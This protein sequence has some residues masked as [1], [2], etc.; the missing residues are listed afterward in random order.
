[1][2]NVNE[3]TEEVKK[4]VVARIK[5]AISGAK[6]FARPIDGQV[7]NIIGVLDVTIPGR[8][9]PYK[10]L[11]AKTDQGDVVTF[12]PSWLYSDLTDTKGNR[13]VST[14]NGNPIHDVDEDFPTNLKCNKVESFTALATVYEDGVAVRTIEKMRYVYHWVG[15]ESK[16]EKK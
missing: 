8:V 3:L 10:A 15:V 2:A 5:D 7:Y 9:K 11:K 4:D 14:L 12:W 13:H 16:E 6:E 1:M